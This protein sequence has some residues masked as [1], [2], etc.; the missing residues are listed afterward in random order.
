MRANQGL[1]A[2][3]KTVLS[4]LLIGGICLWSESAIAKTINI[5]QDK[6][7]IAHNSSEIEVNNGAKSLKGIRQESDFSN[8]E[9]TI[10]LPSLKDRGSKKTASYPDLVYQVQN[11]ARSNWEVQSASQDWLDLNRGDGVQDLV[12]L[13]IWRF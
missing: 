2:T 13:V 4:L 1:N 9:S 3:L 7:D 11:S 8:T 10:D 6:Q 5:T 12:R